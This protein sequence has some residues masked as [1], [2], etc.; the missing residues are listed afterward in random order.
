MEG[1]LNFEG[2]VNLVYFRR[3]KPKRFYPAFPQKAGE[4]NASWFCSC[5][6]AL[7]GNACLG[8]LADKTPRASVEEP[9]VAL[10][11]ARNP[12]RVSERRTGRKNLSCGQFFRGETLDGGPLF[13]ER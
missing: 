5:S 13:A 7:G 11:R 8:C 9:L 2:K 1:G 12:L 3:D 6:T 10:R 4:V